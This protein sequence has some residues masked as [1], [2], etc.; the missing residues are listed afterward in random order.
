MTS[1]FYAACLASYNNGV[2]HGAWIDASDDVDAMGAE[3]SAM[4][5]KSPFPNVVRQDFTCS[6]CGETVT[7]TFG[8][9]LPA[10]TTPKCEHCDDPMAAE[11][12]SYA[13]AEEWAIHGHEGLG[14][15][16]E[17]A[18]LDAIAKR[19]AIAEAADDHDIPVSILMEAMS[20]DSAE[21]PEDYISE[22]YRGQAD[23][24]ADFAEELEEET[25][26]LSEVPERF[27]SY[28]DFERMGR[29]FELSGDF[30]GHWHQGT[31]Y[32]FWNH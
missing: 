8:H 29:D 7:C 25:G 12:D 24:W 9:A 23:S 21:D 20:D 28:I 16:G 1:R 3:V 10:G 4:L 30:S 22:R 31:L 27:R 32:I 18:G 19:F 2:L 14:D 5:R 17:Y 26:G 11:G 6:D 13:S 15:I